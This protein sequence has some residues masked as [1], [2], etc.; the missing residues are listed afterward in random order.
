MRVIGR[1]P[2]TKALNDAVARGLGEASK[3][4]IGEEEMSQVQ[5]VVRREFGRLV[6]EGA[7]SVQGIPKSEFM[8]E[9]EAKRA[10]ERSPDPGQAAASG[11]Q[12]P[13]V[14][15]LDL[16]EGLDP[17]LAPPRPIKDETAEGLQARIDVYERRIQ[18]LMDS[19]RRA[20][21]ALRSVSEGQH[22]QGIASIY[23]TVQGLA[24]QDSAF[25]LKRELLSQ[26]L[27]ANLAL[28]EQLR[29]MA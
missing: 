6:R 19:L 16:D 29:R 20:E 28:K 13:R 17:E 24:P 9:L 5:R 22:P 14:P 12:V 26:M 21:D 10:E 2:L 27:E 3:A 1:D 7:G 23:R 18:K 11:A 8:A 25:H 15:P 4:P